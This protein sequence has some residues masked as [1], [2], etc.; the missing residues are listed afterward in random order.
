[1]K[2]AERWNGK[3]WE[4]Y[5]LCENAV[6]NTD[7]NYGHGIGI[8]QCYDGE[9]EYSATISYVNAIG[10]VFDEDTVKLCSKCLAELKKSVRKRG[11]KLTY[12]KIR[13]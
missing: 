3:D 7:V 10:D 11:Y 12:H 2:T 8:P 1:M 4:K 6:K 9:Q 13:R 5:Q